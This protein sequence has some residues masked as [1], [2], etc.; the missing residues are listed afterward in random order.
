LFKHE[1]FCVWN[2]VS[3]ASTYNFM[4]NARE[5]W[6]QGCVVSGTTD[7]EGNTIYYD[8]KPLSN[9]RITMGL[10]TDTKCIQEY[11]PVD[12][13][14]PITIENVIG[15][16]LSEGGSGDGNDDAAVTYSTLEESLAA[17]DAG[18][19]SFAICQPC[20][21]YD[22]HNYGYGYNDDRYH[23]ANYNY[24]NDDG[25]NNNNGGD[26]FDCYDDADY[27]NV[28]QCMK[29]MAKT[30]MKTATFRDMALANA[31]GTLTDTPLAAYRHAARYRA[32]SAVSVYIGFLMAGCCLWTGTKKFVKV[33]RETKFAPN[34]F[35]EPFLP[36][37]PKS[38]QKES[39]SPSTTGS[40]V[41]A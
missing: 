3:D 8:I 12:K 15:N 1:G 32:L 11:K 34:L 27:T 25:N 37:S 17:W 24:G 16:V 38:S 21:A 36:W 9:G 40:G 14:D 6:P 13:D 35:R 7:T 18:L 20:V 29:F 33:R 30:V 19:D 5:M 41:F 28:N 22:L 4:S 2:A 26:D 10:Y 39:T 31:Q 23:G